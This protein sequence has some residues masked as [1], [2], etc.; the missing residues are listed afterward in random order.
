[1]EIEG[2]QLKGGP[3]DSHNDYRIAMAAAAIVL[4]DLLLMEQKVPRIM[5]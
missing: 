2:R 3:V 5:R 1:M 4:A